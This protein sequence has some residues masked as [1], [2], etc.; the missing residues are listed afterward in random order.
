MCLLSCLMIFLPA[1][2]SFCLDALLRPSIKA[3]TVPVWSL[4]L[5]R[6]QIAVPMFFGGIAKLNS[7]WLHGEPLWAWLSASTDFPLLGQLFTNESVVW[8]M[9][10]GGL[11]VDLLF[12]FYLLNRRARVIGFMVVLAFHFMNA[13]LFDIGIFPWFMI[14][15]TLMFFVPDWPVRVLNNINPKHSCRRPALLFG[16]VVGSLVGGFLPERFDL[17]QARLVAWALR[18]LLIISISLSS[19]QLGREMLVTRVSHAPGHHTLA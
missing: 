1:N 4:W 12:V 13:R 3:V 15:A 9:V 7:D 18:L 17:V 6:F 2:R 19:R 10:Y 16:L 11:L 5:L 8:V 14:V